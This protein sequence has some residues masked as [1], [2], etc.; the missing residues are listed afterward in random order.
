[1]GIELSRE[2]THSTFQQREVDI[3]WRN[4]VERYTRKEM[5]FEGDIFPALQGIAR[6]FS[7]MKGCHYYAGS[8]EDSLILDLMWSSSRNVPSRPQTWRAP[9][10]SWASIVGPV[11]YWNN[12]LRKPCVTVLSVEVTPVGSDP[13]GEI[14]SATLTLAGSA[15]SGT[16]DFSSGSCYLACQT[17]ALPSKHHDSRTSLRLAFASDYDLRLFDGSQMW[18]MR[19]GEGLYNHFLILRQV[20]E[21]NQIFERVGMEIS[22]SELNQGRHDLRYFEEN[23]RPLT[24]TII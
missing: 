12:Y 2:G 24:A 17:K 10:W 3:Q 23:A 9:S 13:F 21:A 15:V 4:I 7:Q 8:W 18:G 20:D 5:K 16:L 1:M 19:M 14:A 22:Y 11:F 6:S